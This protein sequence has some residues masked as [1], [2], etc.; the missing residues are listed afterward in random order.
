[1]SLSLTLIEIVETTVPEN[2]VKNEKVGRR[3]EVVTNLKRW[4]TKRGTTEKKK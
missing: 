1:M 3:R 4:E 2:K